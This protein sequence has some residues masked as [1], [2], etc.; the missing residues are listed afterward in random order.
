M[1]RKQYAPLLSLCLLLS[2]SGCEPKA[3]PGD[4]HIA[5]ANKMVAVTV[6]ESDSDE[7]QVCIVAEGLVYAEAVK[8]S[9]PAPWLLPTRADASVLKTLTLEHGERFITSDGYTFGMPSASV[10]KAGAKTKYSVLGLWKRKK[11][12]DVPF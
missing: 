11:V 12:I 9:M 2:I 4:D 7:W 5:D 1:I 10:S 8:V 3:E 6:L